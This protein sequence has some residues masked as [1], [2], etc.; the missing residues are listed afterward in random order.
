ML[1]NTKY[2]DV[3]NERCAQLMVYCKRTLSPDSS[4]YDGISV[5]NEKSYRIHKRMVA[6]FY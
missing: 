1:C 2:E 5:H 4:E 6:H 3:V